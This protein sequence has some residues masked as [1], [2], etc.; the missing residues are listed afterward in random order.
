[1]TTRQR[2]AGSQQAGGQMNIEQ[3]VK[4]AGRAR[5]TVGQTESETT[6]WRNQYQNEPYV[7]RGESFSDYEPAYRAGIEARNQY[8]GQRFD[9]V[10]SNLRKDWQAQKGGSSLDWTKASQASRAAWD[11]AGVSSAASDS[12]RRQSQP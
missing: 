3:Q 7:S 2:Q 4:S 6:Y 9:E 1:M 5:N 10:E 8:P 12:D 11:H